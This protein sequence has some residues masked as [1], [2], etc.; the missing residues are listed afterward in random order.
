MN[1]SARCLHFIYLFDVPGALLYMG[2]PSEKVNN[3]CY[4]CRY[5]SFLFRI[6]AF[7]FLLGTFAP[8]ARPLSSV[9][10]GYALRRAVCVAVTEAGGIWIYLY[11]CY[12][13][14]T[15]KGSQG[16]GLGFQL[17][18][19]LYLGGN[20]RFIRL[21]YAMSVNKNGL[22]QYYHQLT[23]VCLRFETLL[24]DLAGTTLYFHN[25]RC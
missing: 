24:R 19:L 10:L 20:K 2:W 8:E 15:P 21:G 1:L 25:E 13:S 9:I 17:F 23:S 11:C 4:A 12:K 18:N 7:G 16:F 6:S 3:I 22:I 5:S 14:I